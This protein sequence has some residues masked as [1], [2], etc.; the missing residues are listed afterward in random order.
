MDRMWY[1]YKLKIKLHLKEM[2]EC[3]LWKVKIKIIPFDEINIIVT[4]YSN[5]RI[6]SCEY[7]RVYSMHAYYTC[8]SFIYLNTVCFRNKVW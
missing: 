5:I 7:V 4:R 8:V 3:N 6:C 1:L 2:A